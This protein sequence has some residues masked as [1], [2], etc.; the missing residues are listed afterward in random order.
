MAV[1]QRLNTGTVF[2]NHDQYLSPFAAFG[3][4]KQSGLGVEGGAE[5]LAEYTNTQTLVRKKTA[6]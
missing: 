3:G 4:H 2:I 6:A 1:A 5:G